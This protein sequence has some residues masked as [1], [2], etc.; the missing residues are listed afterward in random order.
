MTWDV[1]DLTRDAFLGGALHLW[2]P[3]TG[4]RAG[5]DPVLLAACVPATAGDR[6]LDVGCG[7]GTAALC[8]AARVPDLRLTGVEVQDDYAALAQRNGTENGADFT[9][10]HADL[11]ALPVEVRQVQFNHVMMNPP[12]FDRANS[13]SAQDQGRD[14]AFGGDTPLADWLDIGIRRLAPKGHLTLIQRIE[15]LPEV[16][17]AIIP[18][19]GSIVVRPISGRAGTPPQRFLLRAIQ[20]GRAGFFMA[21]TLV[22]HAGESHTGDVESYTETVSAILRDGA[23]LDIAR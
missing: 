17:G 23:K 13:S 5:V 15:R 16:L 22:M 3:R 14:M 2:Q 7:V 21:P 12:Y 10:L 8:L 18:R 4:Y 1:S 20:S 6:V 9:V 11:R 19:L